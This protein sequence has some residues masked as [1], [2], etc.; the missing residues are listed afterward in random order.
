MF[1]VL[2]SIT[3]IVTLLA[4]AYFSLSHFQKPLPFSANNN[5]LILTAHPDDECMFFGPTI[6]SIRTMIKSRI[7]VLCLSTGNADGLGDIR[8]KELIKSCQT[9]NI[10]PSHVKSLN[11]PELQDGMQNHWNPSLIAQIIK[12]YTTKHKIDTIITF[13]NHGISGHP[14]HIAAYLGAKAFVQQYKNGIKLYRLES[15]PVIRKYIGLIDF[16]IPNKG[17]VRM[18]S[19]PLAYLLTH[20]AMRQHKSQLVWFRWLYVSF[21]RYMFINDLIQEDG[22]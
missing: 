7:H 6:T 4:Y 15:L 5:I 9:F 19:P 13:D 20:K 12:D 2:I 14:N 18:I 16:L 21:S 1:I 22:L 17:S 10:Q 11:N 3:F 8:K